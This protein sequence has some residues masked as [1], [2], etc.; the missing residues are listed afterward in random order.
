MSLPG[1]VVRLSSVGFRHQS[2]GD[3]HGTV[4]SVLLVIVGAG[5]IASGAAHRA[6]GEA[7]QP[8]DGLEGG[9]G[10]RHLPQAGELVRGDVH[11]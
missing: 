3:L 2:A 5:L 9:H 10:V 6:I 4:I 7:E 1:G 11:G 8:P